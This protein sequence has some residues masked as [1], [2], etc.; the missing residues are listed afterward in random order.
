MKNLYFFVAANIFVRYISLKISILICK[1][2]DRLI[3]KSFCTATENIL[4]NASV[5]IHTFLLRDELIVNF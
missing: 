2:I 3:N 5:R 4:S 1:L